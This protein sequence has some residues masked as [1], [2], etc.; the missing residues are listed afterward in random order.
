MTCECNFVGC[1]EFCDCE[2][3]SQSNKDLLAAPTNRP[4]LNAINTR[5]GDY[6]AFLA[7]AVRQLSD[8]EHP[9]LQTLGTRDVTDPTIAL[10]DAWSVVA[11]VLTFYRDR[12][13]QE[14]YLRTA[15]E[16]RSLRELAGMAGYSPR[17]GI[18]ATTHLAY[19]LDPSAKPVTIDAGSKAQTV[20]RPG[21][22]MQ[23]FETDKPLDARAEWSQLKPRLDRPAKINFY[24]ALTR[25]TLRIADASQV[26]RPGERVLFVFNKRL[27]GQ[28]VREVASAKPNIEKRFVELRLKPR[29]GFSS[30]LDDTER[31]VLAEIRENL[32]ALQIEQDAA[33]ASETHEPSSKDRERRSLMEYV[34]SFF[35]GSSAADVA[36]LL[37]DWATRYF[38]DRRD[39][40]VEEFLQ[41]AKTQHREPS[42]I[43]PTTTDSLIRQIRRAAIVNVPSQGQ[44][45]QQANKGLNADGAQRLQLAQRSS[46]RW[47][48]RSMRPCKPRRRTYCSTQ[49]QAFTFSEMYLVP[50]VQ[51]RQK[52]LPIAMESFLLGS[53][54][55][56]ALTWKKCRIFRIDRRS[57]D[58]P[59]F[60]DRRHTLVPK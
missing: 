3:C 12:L 9:R 39:R 48:S 37:P 57:D 31:K 23:T 34:A 2:R 60:C 47:T 14:A 54:R 20:P 36:R 33:I 44:T 18:S 10:V 32:K 38:K 4:G 42:Q 40:L 7:D 8:Y 27:G 19:Q 56:T 58:S 28:I 49:C 29:E 50:S 13:T 35:L 25:T 17:P 15:S 6:R 11:D 51:W 43:K 16:E 53:G 5:L 45:L 59:E 46:H 55:S 22:T 30:E 21:E 26:V 1:S 24:D 52:K 41:L